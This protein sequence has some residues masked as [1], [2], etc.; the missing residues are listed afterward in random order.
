M[1]FELRWI[2]GLKCGRLAIGPRPLGGHYLPEQIGK[3]RHAGVQ[4]VVSLMEPQE[5]ARFELQNE[6]AVCAL[7]KIDFISFPVRDHAVPESI[8]A[9]YTLSIELNRLLDSDR[10]IFIHCFA[11]L[12]RS[13]LLA[14]CALVQRGGRP[15]AACD[16]LSEARGFVVPETPE[17]LKWI[18]TFDEYCR[19]GPHHSV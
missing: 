4:I 12:G 14:A 15:L 17:Q 2:K 10:S 1:Q 8:K 13:A 3:L 16:C 6:A 18:C 11:G 9:I 19:N 5:A 7:N